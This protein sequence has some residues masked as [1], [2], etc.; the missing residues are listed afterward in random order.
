MRF[1]RWSYCR[2][3]SLILLSAITGC[4]SMHHASTQPVA[5]TQN[6][7]APPSAPMVIVEPS[8]TTQPA[9]AVVAVPKPKPFIALPNI[10]SS[11]EQ[12]APPVA[13][14]D[15]GNGNPGPGLVPKPK[16]F[17]AVPRELKPQGGRPSTLL[18]EHASPDSPVPL[19]EYPNQPAYTVP[20]FDLHATLTQ[21]DLET[22]LGKPAQIADTSD[23]WLVYRLVGDRELWL[24]FSGE[25]HDHLD[26]A[27]VIRGAEDGY[28]RDRVF[29]ADN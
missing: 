24:H 16:P 2:S 11:N 18:L 3:A 19:S 20:V 10:F 12:Q 14:A 6:I 1:M 23:P 5:S 29:S 13:T 8:A 27:D 7:T 26:A 21:K 22:R 28:V 4:A 25:D 17:I 9:V 15:L